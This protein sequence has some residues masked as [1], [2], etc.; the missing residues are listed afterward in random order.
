MEGDTVTMQDI[1]RYQQH[2]IDEQR[3]V[4]GEYQYTGVQ[5]IALRRFDEFG[6]AY[7][8]RKLSTLSLAARSW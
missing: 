5:P 4:V 6:I 1:V 8:H 3:R 7:D 2:G